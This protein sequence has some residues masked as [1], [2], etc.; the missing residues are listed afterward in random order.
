MLIRRS[1]E[2]EAKIV[3]LCGDHAKWRTSSVWDSNTCSFFAGTRMSWRAIVYRMLRICRASNIR[4]PT[5][6]ALPVIIRWSLAG[7]KETARSSLSCACMVCSGPALFRVSH[8]ERTYYAY[9]NQEKSCQSL[10]HKHFIIS[11]T[12][13]QIF[14]RRMPVNILWII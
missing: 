3:G 6:S 10:Q 5:L 12:R 2:A 9:V 1:L 14:L 13:E 7:L 4:A 8:L 11:N